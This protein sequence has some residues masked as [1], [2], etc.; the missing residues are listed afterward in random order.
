MD[1]LTIK[2]KD[3]LGCDNCDKCCINRGDIKLTPINVIQISKHLSITIEEFLKKYT[4]ELKDEEPEIAIKA[5]GERKDCIFYDRRE[6]HCSIHKV[7]PMQCVMYPLVPENLKRDYFY[8]KGTCVCKDKQLIKIEKWLNGNHGIYK[9]YKNI[10]IEWIKLMEFIQ[11][12]W[13]KLPVKTRKEIKKILFTEYNLQKINIKK[14]VRNNMEKV[15][16]IYINEVRY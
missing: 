2:D 14:Q 1:I 11:E 4:Y 8:N 9:K 7:E 3:Y 16:E 6:K 5:V 12:N 10:Y 13:K 15:R